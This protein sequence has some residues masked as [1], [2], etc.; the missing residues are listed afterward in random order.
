MA[1]KQR[2]LG[3]AIKETETKLN[4]LKEADKQAKKQLESGN[5]GQDKY[6]A[7]QREI[8]DTENSLEELQKQASQP[9]KFSSGLTSFGNAAK[10][11]SEKTKGLS[12]AAAGLLG[13][14]AATV[15]ATEELRTDLSKLDNNARSAGV[16][17]D[18]TR[19]AFEAF[20]VVSDEMDSS[21]EATSNLLQ[22]GFTESN[23]QKAVEGLS[24]AY[25]RFPDTLKIESL[26]DS[27]QETLATGAATGQFGELLDRLGIGADNF[28]E[29]LKSCT[30][31]AEKQNYALQTL[32]DAGLMDTYDGWLENNKALAE[33]KQANLDFQQALSKLADT[34]T[35]LIT[36]IT[37]FGTKAVEAFT[38]L[39]PS[40][41]TFIIALVAIIAALS[42]VLAGIGSLATALA[43]LSAP[44]LAVIAVIAAL[45]ATITYLWAT[46]EDFRD[47]VSSI[48]G[49]IQGFFKTVTSQIKDI[50]SNFV[51]LASEIWDQYGEEISEITSSAFNIIKSTISTVLTVIQNIIDLFTSLL[52]G[53]WEGAW[54]AVKNIVTSVLNYVKTFVSNAFN[55]IKNAISVALS[56]AYTMVSTIFT[57]I[58]NTVSNL[59]SAAKNAAVNAFNGLKSGVSSAISSIPGIVSGIFDQVKS[60]ISNLISSAWSWGSDFISGLKDGIVDGINGIL[61]AVGDVADSIA[62][63]LHFSRPDKGPLREYETWMP[64][65][66]KGLTAGIV[67]NIPMIENAVGKLAASMVVSPEA[68]TIDY[69][70]LSG[71]FSDAVGGLSPVFYIDERSFKRGL[72][73]MGVEFGAKVH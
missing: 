67:D 50:I 24:G 5:L 15:P 23:L 38:S 47:G 42:P 14:M 3:D 55:L 43:G 12:T 48:W 20:N 70:K 52:Q 37:E 2:L 28:S 57:G 40:A 25:L 10:T 49:E 9:S 62:E 54:N 39:S 26:A 11:A 46:N 30:T 73:G 64:D 31:E 8:I 45:V 19:E 21:V 71:A 35:P 51:E 13:A 65:M 36:K 61:G 22:A 7:L 29:G 1:Q 58:K 69:T 6:D 53:D 59:A 63:L 27:L 32:A 16:S 68:Q 44:I 66:M 34:I 56:A 33:N 17:I 18:S 4:T 60:I 72:K 41:Q